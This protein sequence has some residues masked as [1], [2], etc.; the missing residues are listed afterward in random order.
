MKIL[1]VASGGGHWLQLLR[2]APAFDGCRIVY[3]TINRG[4]QAHVPD[5]RLHVVRDATRWDRF[6]VLIQA[7]QTLWIVIRERPDVIV[8][9]GAAPGFFSLV[10]GRLVRARTIWID[11]IANIDEVSMSGMR[12]RRYADLWLTQWEHLAEDDGP[13][14]RGAVL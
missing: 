4:Y 6:G 10:W 8:S 12:A 1:A 3:V 5:S 7:L 14:Y 2:V 13:D 11:S 9:T